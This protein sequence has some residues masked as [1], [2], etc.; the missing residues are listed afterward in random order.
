VTEFLVLSGKVVSEEKHLTLPRK[1]SSSVTFYQIKRVLFFPI[2][3]QL[4][5]LL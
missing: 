4:E 5:D 2:L 3:S 1:I